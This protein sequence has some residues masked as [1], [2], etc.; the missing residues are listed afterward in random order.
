MEMIDDNRPES[1]IYF[2]DGFGSTRVI[3][4]QIAKVDEN[5]IYL[6]R[7]DGIVWIALKDIVKVEIVKCGS[8]YDGRGF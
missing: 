8:E 7:R 5:F 1:K 3:R 4:G 2:N 6:K